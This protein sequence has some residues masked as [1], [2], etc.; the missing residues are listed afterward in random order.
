MFGFGTGLQLADGVAS[1]RKRHHP[2][3]IL[4]DGGQDTVRNLGSY[5]CREK[6]VA[7]CI[8]KT[9]LEP[10]LIKDPPALDA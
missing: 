7:E 5:I 3:S 4:Q 9:V 1:L 6:G 10:M 8:L 2:K